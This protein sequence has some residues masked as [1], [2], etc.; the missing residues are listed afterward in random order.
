MKAEDLIYYFNGIM[1]DI[2]PQKSL[3]KRLKE[4]KD[5]KRV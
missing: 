4:L 2:E 5:E 3:K 1:N